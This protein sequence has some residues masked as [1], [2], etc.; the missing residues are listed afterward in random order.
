MN[1]EWVILILVVLVEV[2]LLN[3]IFP[4]SVPRLVL[5]NVDDVPLRGTD[6]STGSGTYASATLFTTNSIRVC[7]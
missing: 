4:L 5:M 1:G 6:R 7:P 2:Y 3:L